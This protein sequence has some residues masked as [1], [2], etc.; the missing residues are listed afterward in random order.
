MKKLLILIS[1]VLCISMQAQTVRIA[2]AG[3]LR[4]ILDEIKEKYQ[5]QSPKA[6]IDVVLGASGAL[7]QQILNGAN[8]DV[9]MSADKIYPDKLKSQGA[10]V[11]EVKTYAFG[12]LVLWSNTLDVSKGIEML[13][14]KSVTRIAVAKPDVAPYGARAIECLKYYGIYEK[15]KEKLVF[16]DN[17][18]QAAQFAQSG[19]AEVAFLAQALV[20]APDLKGK[21]VYLDPKCYKPVEQAC[22]LLKTWERNPEATRFMKFILSPACKPI[23]EKYGFTVK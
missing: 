17:I 22:V 19:N 20:F 14:D 13:T 15:V 12:K 6:K 2:A 8:F 3:N 18:A 7:T 9:F 5:A 1:L 4:Y 10:A 16:A 23:F 21:F 11:G